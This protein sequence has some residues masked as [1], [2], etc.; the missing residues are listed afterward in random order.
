M[1]RLLPI[2]LALPVL[3]HADE[4]P[5]VMVTATRVP[6]LIETVPAG[7]TVLDRADMVARGIT[8]LTEALATVPGLRVAQSGG[9]GGNAS[10]FIRGSNSN[11]V[12]VLR[13]GI[14]LNDP[15]DPGGLFNFGVDSLADVER[16]EV[17]RGP[18]S[19]LYG[20]G[21]IGGVIN[22]ITRRG[23]GP[24]TGQVEIA[25]GLPA[26]ARLGA[27]LSGATGRFDYHLSAEARD[28]AGF[29]TTP[30]R[31]SVHTGA[32]NP[33][34]AAVATANLGA[35]LTDDTSLDLFL[36]ARS[37]TF[38]I[39]ALGFP[40]YDATRYRGF[41]TATQG[42]VAL[43]HHLF[44]GAWQTTLSVGL[45]QTDRHYREPLELADPNA[46]SQDGRYHARR[47]DLR[48]ENTIRL[49][50]G[51]WRDAAL[52]FGASHT[53]DQIN[54]SLDA[55]FAGF[56][57]SSRTR[58]HAATDAAH[59]GAQGTLFNRL[60]LTA[61]ARAETAR[62]AGAAGTWRLGAVLALP[63]LASRA[64]LAAGTAFR[65]PSLYDLFGADS[66]GYRGNPAL[67]PER[68]LGWEAGWSV[69][70][71]DGRRKPVTI[72]LTYFHN[73]IDNLIQIVYGPG[74]LTSTSQNVAKA[75]AEGIEASLTLRPAEKVE[76]IISFTHTDTRDLA[77]SAP[78]LRRPREQASV[79]IRAEPL[80]GL[81]IAPE[82]IY[83]GA[84]IDFIS[85][86]NGFPVGPGRSKGGAV[87]NLTA[88]YAITERLT[89]F[90]LARNI[91]NSRFEPVNGY[92]MPG[93]TLILGARAGF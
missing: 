67:K 25:A 24:A 68:S 52:R 7:V 79:T 78:L 8:T 14:P 9:A 33:Y 47:A 4:T 80:P 32:R 69:D 29:D 6:T 21:A 28:E 65:A 39:D 48:W 84:F 20:S 37:A 71:G 49:E 76:A 38:L 26:Q 22:L 23:K 86:D 46:T 57:Y 13:D 41:D 27:R 72:D 12:L 16:I 83:T 56:P 51:P 31:M 15:S 75:R 40:N 1:R 43:T 62:Y 61:D 42:R 74:F 85:D 11:H 66:S 35:A 91:G 63:E 18:M 17:V 77:T 90:G 54:T 55:N 93:T 89:L 5:D 88:N 3:A 36:R 73:R 81:T 82:L 50:D 58:A 30:R 59:A 92:Q 19:S 70:L 45:L 34:R 2:L 87:F 60:T 10:V 64:R 53:L 44:D